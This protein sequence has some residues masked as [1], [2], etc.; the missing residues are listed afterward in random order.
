MLL[1]DVRALFSEEVVEHWFRGEIR[2]R[3]AA[4]PGG[5]PGVLLK[6]HRE[7]HALLQMEI[8]VAVDTGELED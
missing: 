2:A 6:V 8:P 5:N 7:D 4:P 3:T 1:V